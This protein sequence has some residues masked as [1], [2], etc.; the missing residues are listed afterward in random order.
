MSNVYIALGS[1]LNNPLKNIRIAIDKISLIPKS[2]LI[3]ISSFYET[4]PYGIKN[5]PNYINAVILIKTFLLPEILLKYMQKIERK[6]N[7]KKKIRKWGP[8][9][10]DIDML[11]FDNLIINNNRLIVPHY[12][13][14]NRSF[15]II[16]LIEISPK[17]CL[18]NGI[19]VIKKL[20]NLNNINLR[21]IHLN[22]N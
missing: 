19:P 4:D 14:E 1:N 17:I 15:F 2:K 9:I 12:D 16:P 5:Q 11:L 8:R 20:K 18:P 22:N 13:I 21:K 10:L 7:R 3:K 6:Y